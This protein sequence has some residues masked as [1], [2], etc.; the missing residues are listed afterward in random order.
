M[1]DI[2]DSS[3]AQDNC[4]GVG[5][6]R[7]RQN[8]HRFS[9]LG[10]GGDDKGMHDFVR[11]GVGGDS[12]RVRGASVSHSQEMISR[13]SHMSMFRLLVEDRRNMFSGKSQKVIHS[14]KRVTFNTSSVGCVGNG[15]SHV[16]RNDQHNINHGKHD[17]DRIRRQDVV[18][19]EGTEGAGVG[20]VGTRIGSHGDGVDGKRMSD[21]VFKSSFE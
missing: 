7:V 17:D 21:R 16:N 18:C 3:V 1:K 19:L 10:V 4:V 14:V 6:Q 12:S 5:G 15:A 20:G 13:F 11:V 9:G 2:E 8:M